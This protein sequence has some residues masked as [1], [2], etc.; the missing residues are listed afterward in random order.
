L[1]I[2]RCSQTTPFDFVVRHLEPPRESAYLPGA[3]SVPAQHPPI[4]EHFTEETSDDD[5][6]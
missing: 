4:V 2:E 5:P 3:D 1:V 6:T